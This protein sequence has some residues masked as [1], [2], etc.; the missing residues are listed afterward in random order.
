MTQEHV[1]QP[2]YARLTSFDAARECGYTGIVNARTARVTFDP[3]TGRFTCP[4]CLD[5]V[6]VMLT[7]T[8]APMNETETE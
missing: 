4:D 8:P 6:T 5:T 3:D 1:G 2:L 7:V